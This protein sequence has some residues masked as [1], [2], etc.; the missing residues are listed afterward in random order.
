MEGEEQ[1]VVEE[2]T[3]AVEQAEVAGIRTSV[4]GIQVVGEE[5]GTLM[6]VE[7]EVRTL[8]VVEAVLA[9]IMAMSKISMWTTIMARDTRHTMVLRATGMD[10]VQAMV[11]VEARVMVTLQVWEWVRDRVTDRVMDRAMDP[12]QAWAWA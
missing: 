5:D 6:M 8:V 7:V 10:Q 12:P 11:T 2:I 4:A 3:K 9:V 1:V